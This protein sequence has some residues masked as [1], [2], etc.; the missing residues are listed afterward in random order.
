M[1]LADSMF[2]RSSAMPALQ[3]LQAV[4]GGLAYAAGQQ[5]AAFASFEPMLGGFNGCL[6]GSVM[7]NPMLQQAPQAFGS[8]LGG[9]A[10]LTAASGLFGAPGPAPLGPGAGQAALLFAG[11]APLAGALPDLSS[12][13]GH[14]LPYLNTFG[15]HADHHPPAP[16][17][18][19]SSSSSASGGHAPVP[20]PHERRC[21]FFAGV[22]PIITTETLMALFSQFGTVVDLNLFKPWS[23]SKTSKGCG[24]VVFA[25]SHAAA[26]ALDTLSGKFQW[27]GA[28]GPMIIEWMDPSKQHKKARAQPLAQQHHQHQQHHHMLQAHAAGV[29]KAVQGRAGLFMP[30][31]LFMQAAQIMA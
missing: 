13:F 31:Q 18:A 30:N 7:S 28:R 15:H 2:S 21:I 14:N 19:K 5:H 20:P 1:L 17:S 25:D 16:A 27:P 23:G 8:A 11:Q 10:G 29:Y 4:P 26:A 12:H 24:L 3:A 22:T 9:Y 6:D